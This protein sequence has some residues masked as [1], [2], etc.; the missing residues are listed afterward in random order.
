MNDFKEMS[1]KI[2]RRIKKKNGEKINLDEYQIFV[3][4]KDVLKVKYE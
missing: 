4:K 1:L 2:D 3:N